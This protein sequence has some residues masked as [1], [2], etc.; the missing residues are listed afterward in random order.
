MGFARFALVSTIR[1]QRLEGQNEFCRA[2]GASIGVSCVDD[3][4]C[5][6]VNLQEKCSVYHLLKWNQNQLRIVPDLLARIK[7]ERPG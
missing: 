1:K 4:V 7:T 2:P 6:T 3:L 5:F